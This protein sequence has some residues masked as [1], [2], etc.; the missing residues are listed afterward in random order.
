MSNAPGAPGDFIGL[1]FE[2]FILTRHQTGEA[3]IASAFEALYVQCKS[4]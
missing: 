4:V 2:A 1:E 3:S